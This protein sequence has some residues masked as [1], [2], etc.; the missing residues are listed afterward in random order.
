MK[1]SS[2]LEEVTHFQSLK[3]CQIDPIFQQIFLN[4]NETI[5]DKDV[6]LNKSFTRI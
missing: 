3:F 6:K 2:K 5:K 4:K 1:I